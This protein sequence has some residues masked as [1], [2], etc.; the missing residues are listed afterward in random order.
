MNAKQEN[1]FIGWKNPLQGK[2]RQ[3]G[4]MKAK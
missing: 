3:Q 1:K 2:A 4:S